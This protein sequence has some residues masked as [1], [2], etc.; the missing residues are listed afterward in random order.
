MLYNPINNRQSTQLA[1]KIKFFP[2]QELTG[3][4]KKL[5]CWHKNI[6]MRKSDI[7][8]ACDESLNTMTRGTRDYKIVWAYNNMPTQQEWERK[9]AGFILRAEFRSSPAI[10]DFAVVILNFELATSKPLSIKLGEQA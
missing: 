8:A 9:S 3:G 10:P 7:L 2:W 6:C 5:V 4:A 1:Y